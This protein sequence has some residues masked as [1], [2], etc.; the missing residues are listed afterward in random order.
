MSNR[1]KQIRE[2]PYNHTS[3]SDREIVLRLLGNEAW[4]QIEQL[5]DEHRIGRS[6]RKLFE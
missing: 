4:Q 6:V 5:R 3:F 2:I 1:P